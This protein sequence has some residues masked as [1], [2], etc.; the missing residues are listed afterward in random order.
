M[1]AAAAR[2][3]R[4][5]EVASLARRG[6]GA[7]RRN[8]AVHEEVPECVDGTYAKRD[9][10]EEVACRRNAT[11]PSRSVDDDPHLLV[12]RPDE[13]ERSRD[14][15]HP[16]AGLH[17]RLRAVVQPLGRRDEARV[18]ARSRRG[19]ADSVAQ[20]ASRVC[21]GRAPVSCKLQ[22]ATCNGAP[23]A[24]TTQC[25]RVR[26]PS[27]SISCRLQL[28]PPPA[29]PRARSRD[30]TARPPSRQVAVCNFPGARATRGPRPKGRRI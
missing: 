19:H 28:R 10:K 21:N 13:P 9:I 1:G 16:A 7:Q 23:P 17:D 5:R 27:S 8:R 30:A 29:S 3:A 26:R 20:N 25:R 15:T 6:G 2:A 24:C 11:A 22:T 4:G 14:R 12:A 18:D